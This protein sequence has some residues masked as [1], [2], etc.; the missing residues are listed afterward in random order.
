MGEHLN[1]ASQHENSAIKQH[2]FS[3]TVCCNV[4]HD[5]NSFEV[6]K[7]CKSDFQAKIHEALLIKKHTPSLNKHLYAH[8]SSF[9]LNVYK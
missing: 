8:G 7:Q 2:I 3:C 1:L 5:V 6:L 9:L 4:R